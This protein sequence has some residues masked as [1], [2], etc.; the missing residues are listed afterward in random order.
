M[1]EKQRSAF[2]NAI[3]RKNPG[4]VTSQAFGKRMCPVPAQ[5]WHLGLATSHLVSGRES[6]GNSRLL[7]ERKLIIL[8]KKTENLSNLT[9]Q[10]DNRAYFALHSGGTSSLYQT[11]SPQLHT[12][13]EP[14]IYLKIG[15][16][17]LQIQIQINQCFK[18]RS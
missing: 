10:V 15:Y 18:S 12:P 6:F 9:E 13:K 16:S 3:S 7:L 14:S 11:Q 8:I 1:T 4:K 2:L 5:S 17:I